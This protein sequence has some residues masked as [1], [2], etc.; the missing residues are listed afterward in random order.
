M[1]TNRVNLLTA[2]DMLRFQ[3]NLNMAMID[4]GVNM[5]T[6]EQMTEEDIKTLKGEC[7]AADEAIEFL[8]NAVREDSKKDLQS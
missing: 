2:C 7:I 6:G 5:M 8:E 4:H 1:I 3:I